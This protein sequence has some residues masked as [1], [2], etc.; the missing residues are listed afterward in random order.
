MQTDVIPKRIASSLNDLKLV[1]ELD[2]AFEQSGGDLTEAEMSEMQA[3]HRELGFY[4]FLLIR[5][6]GKATPSLLELCKARARSYDF[7]NRNTGVIE[8]VN[9]AARRGVYPPVGRDPS[10]CWPG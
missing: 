1:A 9:A 6:L 3:S 10:C 5:T 8:I 4:F 7:F 2:V